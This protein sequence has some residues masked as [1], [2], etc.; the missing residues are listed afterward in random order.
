[1]N[2]QLIF[3]TFENS[4]S[5]YRDIQPRSADRLILSMDDQRSGVQYFVR[6]NGALLKIAFRGS[7]SEKDWHSNL[8]FW[9]RCIP[10]DNT[11]SK[12]RVHTG[13]IGRYKTPA[14]REQIL[15]L[16]TPDIVRVQITGHSYGAALAVLCAV[17]VQYQ[18]PDRDIE[19][20]VFGCPRVGNRAFQRSY[21]ARVCKTLRIENGNDIV[22]KV[23]PALFGFHHVGAKIHVGPP[24]LPFVLSAD[25]HRLENYLSGLCPLYL[26]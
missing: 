4:A 16:I 10:Y 11:A 14:C 9:K 6:K 24:R 20:V 17:D 26:P 19:V 3:D 13:F 5:A 21:N 22:T 1:M 12:I 15:R 7:D 18:F 8:M 2:K 25:A 23:P